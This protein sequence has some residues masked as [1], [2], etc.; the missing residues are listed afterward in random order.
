[1]SLEDAIRH[2][3]RL[4]PRLRAQLE[5]IALARGLQQIAFSAVLPVA[6]AN[7]DAGMFSLGVT[8]NS[9]QL[10]KSPTGFNFIPSVG[11]VAF[12]L[13]IGTNFE[14]AELKVRWLL[15]DF[16]RRLGRYEQAPGHRHRPVL[17]G[18]DTAPAL[19][20]LLG[21]LRNDA[22]ADRILDGSTCIPCMM[23]FI[24]S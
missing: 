8:G 15:F 21:H 14:L 1:M 3:Y 6:A 2:A 11:A 16:G 19:V 10:P 5:F 13:N 17:Q 7:Y 20:E 18:V 24:T 4:Q 9:I 23:P 22:W 12:G